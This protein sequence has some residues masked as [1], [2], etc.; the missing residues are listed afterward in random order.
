MGSRFGAALVTVAA[1][2][3][4]LVGAAPS[5]AAYPLAQNGRIVFEHVD[6][7]SDDIWIINPD[8]SGATNLTKTADPIFNFQPAISPNAQQIAYVR[9]DGG[10]NGSDLW[11]MNVDGS[12]QHPLIPGTPEADET[13]T[14]SPDGRMLAFVRCSA[15][16]CNVFL[17][18]ADGS[19]PHPLTTFPPAGAGQGAYAPTFSPDGRTIAFEHYVN[20]GGFSDIWA[21]GVDGSGQT[22]LTKTTSTPVFLEFTPDYS[23]DGQR[24]TYARSE[25]SGTFIGLMNAD[26]SSQSSITAG[27]NGNER[28]PAFSPDGKQLVFVGSSSA[29]YQ[30]VQLMNP[31]GSNRRPV[32]AQDATNEYDPAWEHV[33]MC[34]GRR[35][36]IIG[37]DSGESLKGTKG[38]DVIV[39]NGGKDTIK[40]LKGK[41]RI[42]GGAG[43]DKLIGGKGKDRCVGGP[44]KDKG[45]G[46]E[47]GKI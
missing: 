33:Y 34:G 2:C 6:T 40:G 32:T 21:I 10:P 13:P 42:C 1:A 7:G 11:V 18:G 23:P 29:P 43:K 30:H 16:N 26:G 44:G 46:C 20:T 14:Y 47:K 3:A 39:A 36:T 31:D 22:D 38:P 25:M 4:L 5:Q 28:Y 17:A 24:I 15:G 9:D 37:S 35:A 45:K 27:H 41:D 8:G 19:N 12:G